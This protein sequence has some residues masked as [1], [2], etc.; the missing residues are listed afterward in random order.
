MPVHTGA[1]E[2]EFVRHDDGDIIAPTPLNQRARIRAI[3]KLPM[4][5]VQSI[6]I[7]PIISD[8]QVVGSMDANRRPIRILV[9]GRSIILDAGF[10]VPEPTISVQRSRAIGPPRHLRVVTCEIGSRPCEFTAGWLENG[11]AGQIRWLVGS[12]WG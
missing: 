4:C 3:K 7:D 8:I 10:V 9:I 12:G 1:V 11:S 2:F 5:K 6:R